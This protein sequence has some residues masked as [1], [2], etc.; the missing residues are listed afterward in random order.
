MGSKGKAMEEEHGASGNL[1]LQEGDGEGLGNNDAGHIKLCT[2]G[3]WRPTEDARLIELVAQFGPQNW[4]LIAEKLEARSGKSCRLRWFN[5]LDPKINKRAFSEEEEE[6]LMTAHR[7]YGNKWATIA[8]LFPG[9]TDNAVKNHWH[10]VMARKHREQSSI[11]RRRKSAHLRRRPNNNNNNNNDNHDNGG[12]ESSVSSAVDESAASTCTDLSLST[13]SSAMA[14][15]LRRRV[16]NGSNAPLHYPLFQPQCMS[17]GTYADEA[18]CSSNGYG[19]C[20]AGGPIGATLGVELC[21]NSNLNS[22]GGFT[23]AATGF[24]TSENV[25]AEINVPHFIDFLGVGAT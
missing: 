7:T 17:W 19:L 1:K 3:H 6:R 18:G 11:Y 20:L 12:S 4:N 16:L 9:R 24:E 2:R 8:R 15:P 13:T 5:Q 22:S 21:V 14:P 10:V 25:S 23:A